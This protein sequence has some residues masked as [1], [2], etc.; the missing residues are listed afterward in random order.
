MT[1]ALF[2]GHS[3]AT[4]ERA[5]PLMREETFAVIFKSAVK[6]SWIIV[7]VIS[8]VSTPWMSC[9]WPNFI[10]LFWEQTR[11]SRK[12]FESSTFLTLESASCP[13][14]FPTFDG[15]R[16]LPPYYIISC[17]WL[18]TSEPSSLKANSR[19]S[20]RKGKKKILESFIVENV[21]QSFE[22]FS[23]PWTFKVF[24]RKLSKACAKRKE[25]MKIC[26]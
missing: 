5:V 22:A 10:N 8:R 14:Q 24:G 17:N 26:E 23:F 15:L 4:T 25:N 7:F 11:I 2:R 6:L 19:K 18:A 9:R 20:A 1:S 12:A 16:K 21:G 13:P 3:P